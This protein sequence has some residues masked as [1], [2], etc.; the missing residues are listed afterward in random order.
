MSALISPTPRQHFTN[1]STGEPA[2]GWLLFTYAAGTPATKQT[3]YVSSAGITQNTNPIVLDANGECDLWLTPDIGYKFVFAPPTDTD[4]PTNSIW[5]VDNIFGSDLTA[6]QS[7]WAIA[8]GTANAITATYSPTITSL[9][10]GLLLGVRFAAANTTTTPTFKPD[11]QPVYVV[12]A[13]GG[14]P[15]WPGAIAGN[16]AEGLLRYNLAHTRWEFLNPTP[17]ATPWAIAAGSANVITGAFTPPIATLTDGLL[18]GMRA[19][20]A[21]TTTTPTFQAD[22]TTA[23]TITKKGGSAL[24][25]GDI[26][27]ALAECFLRYNLANTRWEL[28]NPA[29]APTAP[30]FHSQVIAATGTFAIPAGITSLTQFK[31]RLSGGGGA[32]GAAIT[33]NGAA[34]AGGGTGGYIEVVY[35]GF[36]AAQNVTI[37]IGAA[38]AGGAGTGGTGGDTTLAYNAV[39]IATASGGTGGT[40]GVTGSTSVAGGV[41]G[42][43]SASAGASG[44]TLVSS[45]VVGGFGAGSCGQ[46]GVCLVNGGSGGNGG[47]GPL[48][49]GSLGVTTSGG[50]GTSPAGGYGGGGSG[51]YR[52]AGSNVSGGSG[53]AGAVIVEYTL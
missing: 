23:H 19:L 20:A 22:A 3:T 24:V 51:A 14:A 1:P 32:G 25:A 26:P 48:G 46:N 8:S 5:T 21:N 31:F 9:T 40:F 11:A 6:P 43:G 44:L 12:T 30:I 49:F 34:G 37:A 15:L 7:P 16:F 17:P 10:D 53:T 50:A 47:S 39:V 36:T 38:G 28:M 52:A 27:A 35:S 29:S 13:E 41:P 2:N 42:G 4:P 45:T 18:V 33:N